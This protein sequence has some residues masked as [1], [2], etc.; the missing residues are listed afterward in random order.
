MLIDLQAA[1]VRMNLIY[2][3]LWYIC[4]NL[5]TV[6]KTYFHISTCFPEIMKSQWALAP[7]KQK[8]AC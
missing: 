2:L 8:K 5:T 7:L 6:G 1:Y 3:I 4:P